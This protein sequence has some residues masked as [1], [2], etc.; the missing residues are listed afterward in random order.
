MREEINS[1][2]IMKDST[3]YCNIL[4]IKQNEVKKIDGNKIVE[5][6]NKLEPYII[7]SVDD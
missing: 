4:T 1:F 2:G 5:E 3:L 6:D 7:F